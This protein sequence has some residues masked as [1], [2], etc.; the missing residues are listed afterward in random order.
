MKKNTKLYETAAALLAPGKGILAADES[1]STAGKRLAMVHLPNEPEHRQDFREILFTAPGIEEHLSGVIMY[2]SSIRNFTDD[3]VAFPDVLT[4]SGIV[5]GIKVDLGV[6]ELTGFKGEVVTQGLDNLAERF[7]EY[8]DLGAR[9]AKWRMVVTI[10][11]DD[12]PTDE[13]LKMNCIM[14]TRYAQIAQEAGIVP[15]VEPEV[16]HAGDHSLQKAEAVTTRTLQI[17]F[18]TLIEYKVDL[19]G[20]ILKSSMVLAGDK[21]SDQTSPEEVANATLRTFHMS[22][23]HECAGIVFLSGGQTPERSTQNLNAIAKMGEQPWP[24][25]YSFSRA[26]EEPVLKAWGGKKENEDAAKAA[27]LEACKQNS[28]ASL[29][30]L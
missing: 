16:I 14:M 11:E 20:L 4:A 17:L 2:D 12:T 9:F 21:Y 8:Y 5:P 18:S 26:I 27:L 3:G 1:D 7:A 13:V 15:I 30:K 29:G 10:D 25:T 28:L 6:K 23:P 24:I 22:V 19:Q